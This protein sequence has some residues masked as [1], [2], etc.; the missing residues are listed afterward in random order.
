MVC[1]VERFVLKLVDVVEGD[2][3]VWCFWCGSWF[4][5]G[6]GGWC[7][8]WCWSCVYAPNVAVVECQGLLRVGVYKDPVS[9]PCVGVCDAVVPVHPEEAILDGVCP[10]TPF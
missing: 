4:L 7:L 8:V 6:L 1:N 2:V 10:E 5:F 3:F 9:Q